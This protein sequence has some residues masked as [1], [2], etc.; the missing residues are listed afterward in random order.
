MR[1]GREWCPG[2]LSVLVSRWQGEEER[3]LWTND[4]VNMLQLSVMDFAYDGLLDQALLFF[5]L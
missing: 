5:I 2:R 3:E 4:V 1:R